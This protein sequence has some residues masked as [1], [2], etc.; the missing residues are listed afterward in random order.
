MLLCPLCNGDHKEK[1]MWNAVSGEWGD[2]DYYGE[3]TYRLKCW[4]ALNHGI[5]IV[6]V[7]A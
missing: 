5:P 7:K 6:S 4:D 3:R 2:G 1:S